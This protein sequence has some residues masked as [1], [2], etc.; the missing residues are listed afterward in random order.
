MEPLVGRSR[1]VPPAAYVTAEPEMLEDTPDP[2]ALPLSVPC[3]PA[4]P[5]PEPLVPEVRFPPLYPCPD[6]PAPPF[7]VE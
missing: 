2:P 6:V 7:G 1:P 5:P 4:P 3:P